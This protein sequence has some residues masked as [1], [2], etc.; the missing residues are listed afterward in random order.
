M[1]TIATRLIQV[2]LAMLIAMMGFSKL[3]GENWWS[4][5][6]MWLLMA[7]QESRLVDFTW[8]ANYP[9]LIDFWTHAVVLFELSFPVLVWIPLARPLMLAA[10]VAIWTSLALVTGETTF[11][12][13]MV[14][15]SLAFVS[16]TIVRAVCDRPSRE[17]AGAA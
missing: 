14:I 17:L 7:R 9:K 13:M 4:G 3:L 1:A 2:H 8:L 16:P 12:L 10:G 6:G 15:A 11:A 5:T